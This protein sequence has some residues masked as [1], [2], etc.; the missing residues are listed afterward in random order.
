MA[1]LTPAKRAL[2]KEI[3]DILKNISIE[4]RKEQSAIVFKK[5][6]HLKQYQESTRISLYLSTTD[7]IDTLPIL[8]DIFDRGK[9]AFVPQYHGKTMEMVKLKSMKDYEALPLT[10]WNIKQPSATEHRENAL[11]TGKRL[12]HGM[13]YYD[14]YLKRCFKNQTIRPYLVAVGF[15]EQIQEDIPVNENDVPVDIVLTGQ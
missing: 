11:E 3:K 13:G 7:E 10:K 6:C 15:K 1:I 9:E 4:E 5:L 14:K 2:R 8:K 12:G